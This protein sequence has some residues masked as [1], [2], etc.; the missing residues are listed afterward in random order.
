MKHARI[1]AALAASLALT[2]ACTQVPAL[3]QTI[4]PALAAADYPALV[5]L[6]PILAAAQNSAVEPVQATS[7]IDARVAAL[8]AR[9]A[10][11]NGSV[12]NGAERQR[13]AQGFR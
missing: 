5:P 13:L 12:L 10:R 8:K 2:G 4:T 9:A 7:A 1:L 3:D 6:D 11:L